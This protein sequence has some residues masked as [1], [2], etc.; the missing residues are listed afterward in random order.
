MKKSLPALRAPLR[1][2]LLLLLIVLGL[3]LPAVESVVAEEEGSHRLYLPA[4]KRG[5][6]VELRA[7]WVTRF[8]WTSW[9]RPADPAVID[10][11][12]EDAEAAGFNAIFFQVRGTGDAFYRPGPEPWAARVSGEALGVPPPDDWDPLAYFIS[13]AHERGLQLHSYINVYPVWDNCDSAPP[14]DASPT[15][16]YYKLRDAHGVTRVVDEPDERL[17]GL[18]WN[19]NGD[20]HCSDYQRATPASIFVDNHLM[21]V[22]TYLVS[23]YDLDGLH[24]DHIRY[25]GGGTSCDP[26]S[27][28][29]WGGPCFSGAYADWQRQQVSG[30]VARFYEEVVPL[31]SDLMLSAAVWPIYRDI[32][33]WGV[34]G[35]YDRYYQDS[36]GWMEA[37]TI[38]AIMPMIYPAFYEECMEK[39]EWWSRE[40]WQTLVADFQMDSYGRLV[41]PGIGS[42]TCSFEEIEARIQMARELGTGGHALFSY[43]ALARRDYFDDLAAGPYALVAEPPSLPPDAAPELS[44]DK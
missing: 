32:W 33:G 37:G 5:K 40:R 2:T 16:L 6:I 39:R 35:G 10:T 25:G 38:H 4:V 1:L 23:N 7:L 18:Q 41:V 42:D 29:R 19:T 15:H 21:E 36:K 44:S 28:V 27:M 34:S 31:G 17:N 13:R 12:V 8:D 14:E 9:S 43:S 22:A 26:V 30:T 3:S 20:V 11:I 24:L